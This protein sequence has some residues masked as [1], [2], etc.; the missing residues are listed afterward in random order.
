[1]DTGAAIDADLSAGCERAAVCRRGSLT[2]ILCPPSGH[3]NYSI[4]HPGSRPGI[5]G[6]AH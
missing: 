1:M 2:T 3:V 4:I 5:W 6:Q